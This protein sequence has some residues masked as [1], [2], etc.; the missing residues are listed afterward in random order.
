MVLERFGLLVHH[1]RT[2]PDA[3]NSCIA[4]RAIR[5]SACKIVAMRASRVTSYSC[6]LATI[7]A[8]KYVEIPQKHRNY[9]GIEIT[10]SIALGLEVT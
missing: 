1:E 3:N 2:F 5:P 8:P 4:C 6:T 7:N 9:I 10:L